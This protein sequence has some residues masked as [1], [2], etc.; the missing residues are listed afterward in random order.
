MCVCVC[1]LGCK[2]DLLTLNSD[3]I[4]WSR[5]MLDCHQYLPVFFNKNN[6]RTCLIYASLASE[7]WVLLHLKIASSFFFKKNQKFLD[8]LLYFL[9]LNVE[10]TRENKA[11]PK[12]KFCKDWRRP[13]I[14]ASSFFIKSL[15]ILYFQLSLF[16]IFLEWTII[17]ISFKGTSLH[18]T[19]ILFP[20]SSLLYPHLEKLPKG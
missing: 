7:F 8:L 4:I 2:L 14:S 13:G 3:W 1:V 15:E 11:S 16:G 9:P 20:S 18:V 10:N 6:N 12:K 19:I 5:H 17:I